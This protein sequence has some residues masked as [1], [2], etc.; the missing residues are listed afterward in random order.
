M[1]T[2]PAPSSDG[3][4]TA[5]DQSSFFAVGGWAAW[6]TMLVLPVLGAATVWLARDLAA[7]RFRLDVTRLGYENDRGMLDEM[8]RQAAATGDSLH[9]VRAAST[10][11]VAE[12]KA[13]YLV[14]SIADNRL[15]Y[16]LGE[17]VL[18]S[19]RVA[20]GTGKN[21]EQSAGGKQWKFDT[22]RGRLTVVRKDV[23]PE[24][25]PPDWHYIEAAA[26]KG[27]KPYH[28]VK[29]KT[30]PAGGGAVVAVS[31]ENVVTRYPDG[32]EVPFEV[33][34]GKEIRVGSLLVIPPY[35]TNQ[36]RYVGTL[37]SNRLYLGDGYG[38]HGT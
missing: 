2:R 34:E 35:E 16:K 11:E 20:T 14:V 36:R 18:F 30:L 33:R 15:W 12:G 29:G 8:R 9:R 27:L 19:T 17:E 32:R 38:I 6:V 31:G 25:V 10:A 3:A 21:L 7:T 1:P 24:W 5:R 23:D 37:G 22:P 28:L 13:P 26:K 4:P